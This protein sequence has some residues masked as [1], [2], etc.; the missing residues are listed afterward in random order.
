MSGVVFDIAKVC[1]RDGPGIRTTVFLKGC[2][3][4]C[5]WC[6]NPE[7]IDP[8]P[9]LFFRQAR[10]T[11]CQTCE[12]ICKH[13]VHKFLPEHELAFKQCTLCGQCIAQC[14]SHALTIMGKHM[15][16]EQVMAE[17]LADMPFYQASGGGMT[18][19]GGEPLYQA[20]FSLAL[21][22]AAKAQGINTAI[23]TSGYGETE[24]LEKIIPF[25]DYF[26]FDYKINPKYYQKF[27]GVAF[28]V[29][30]R[31]LELLN[32]YN[33]H[34]I[35]RCPIVPGVNDNDSHRQEIAALAQKYKCIK[36]VEMLPYHAL[37]ASK[38]VCVGKF[39]P[40]GH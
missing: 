18:L 37:G 31:N 40:D 36:S 20:E 23:E 16:V 27:T 35:L 17:V 3:L 33:M 1:L 7:S 21:L 32:Q 5:P 29:I 13:N 30:E 4:S 11:G 9:Q 34:V 39:K 8:N 10:C 25:V 26:L 12:K 24:K 28:A 14:Q 15:T 38:A 2:M 6:H 19:S 22:K